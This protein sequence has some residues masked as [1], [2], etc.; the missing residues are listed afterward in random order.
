MPLASYRIPDEVFFESL[1]DDE[2]VVLDCRQ[3]RFYTLNETA[4]RVFE[5]A[6]D[7][8]GQDEIVDRLAKEFETTPDGCRSDV[9]QLLAKLIADGLVVEE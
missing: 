8:L 3:Y 1:S 6:R 7:G 5:S 9:Q 2:A 4:K